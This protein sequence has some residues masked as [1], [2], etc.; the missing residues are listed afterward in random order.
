MTKSVEKKSI[1]QNSMESLSSLVKAEPAKAGTPL[2]LALDDVYPDPDQPRKS[3]PE[4][5]L[6][7]LAASIAEQ[8][9]LQPILRALTENTCSNTG[10]G[11]GAL[12][13]LLRA[14]KRYPPLSTIRQT[15]TVK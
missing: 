11:A 15:I 8:G 2:S 7:S 14:L 12:L 10:R 1:L 9:V 5:G 3:F 6:N 13:S 4:E